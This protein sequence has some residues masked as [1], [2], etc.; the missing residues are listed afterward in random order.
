M[1][2]EK[3]GETA[4]T[5]ARSCPRQVENALNGSNKTLYYCVAYMSHETN[6][7]LFRIKTLIAELVDKVIHHVSKM[8]LLRMGVGEQNR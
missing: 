1:P 5:K 4:E 2:L 3:C 8:T 7:F 6:L